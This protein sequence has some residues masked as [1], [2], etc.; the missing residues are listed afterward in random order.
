MRDVG[1]ANDEVAIRCY[2]DV[3]MGNE[4][5]DCNERSGNEG[6]AAIYEKVWQ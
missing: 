6:D 2:N 1:W 4:E 5:L 3:S